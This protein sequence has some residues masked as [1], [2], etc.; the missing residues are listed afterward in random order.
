MVTFVTL[1][2][3]PILEETVSTIWECTPEENESYLLTVLIR[4]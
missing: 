1:L 2:H 4:F 3:F